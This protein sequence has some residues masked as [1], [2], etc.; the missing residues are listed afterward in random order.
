MLASTPIS[1]ALIALARSDNELTPDPVLNDVAEPSARVIVRVDV[2]RLELL[3]GSGGE[4]HDALLARFCTDIKCEPTAAP[5]V[6]VPV[7]TV[8]L[9]E[10]DR[11]ANGPLM[12]F[13]LLRSFDTDERAV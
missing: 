2:P 9:D 1:D 10:T 7:T 12:S 5:G 6:A 4:Y 13:R 11:A 3:L 8:A